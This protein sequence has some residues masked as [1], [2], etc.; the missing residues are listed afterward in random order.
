MI[1]R[2]AWSDTSL[3][4]TWLTPHEGKIRLMAKGARRPA[5]PFAGKLDLFFHAEVAYV[6]SR[7]TSLHTLRE[8]RLI[9]PFDA[10]AVPFAN[11]FLCG[12]FAELTDLSTESGNPS[13]EMFGL[14]TR[15]IEHLRT[16]AASMRA[17]EH[18]ENEF[19]R[20]LGVLDETS[21]PLVA[22]ETYCGKIPASRASAVRFL[23][24]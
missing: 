3:I 18:F 16:K 6:A 13:P 7:S 24:A 23:D 19:C 15:A 14:L 2:H 21:H 4:T 12:Y 8:I 20:V 17:L 22:I 1:R 9:S 11:V 10:A 5:S